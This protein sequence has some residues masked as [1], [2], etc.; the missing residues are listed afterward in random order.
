MLATAFD[1]RLSKRFLWGLLRVIADTLCSRA[2]DQVP[3]KLLLSC[4][5][6]GTPRCCDATVLHRQ[7]L[8][9]MDGRALAAGNDSVPPPFGGLKAISLHIS[10]NLD[11]PL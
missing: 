3:T 1:D 9:A 4:G 2:S 8:R 6:T 7:K 5:R 11:P 10:P